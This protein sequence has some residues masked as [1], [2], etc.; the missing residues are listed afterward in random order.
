MVLTL[1]IFGVASIKEFVMP[2]MVGI[3]AGCWS[4]VCIAGPLWHLFRTKIAS[5][6]DS[7]PVVTK[8]SGSGDGNDKSGGNGGSGASSKKKSGQSNLSKKERKLQRQKEIE[9]KNKAKITV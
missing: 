7:E 3:V 8:S 1:Y 2:L 4:S 6:K 5:K 9:E